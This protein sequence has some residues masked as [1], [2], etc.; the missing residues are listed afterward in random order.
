LQPLPIR[1]TARLGHSGVDR[2]DETR[3]WRSI[4]ELA[5]ARRSGCRPR[6]PWQIHPG[7]GRRIRAPFLRRL[8]CPPARDPNYPPTIAASGMK[9][10][11]R[12]P[13]GP[14]P[15]D[16]KLTP[17]R[18]RRAAG[19]DRTFRPLVYH[20]C[21]RR[22]ARP[23]MSWRAPELAAL[24]VGVLELI[25]VIGPFASATIVGLV[26]IQQK[27][28]GQRASCSDSP[29]R[30]ACRSTTSSNRSCSA[31]RRGFTRSL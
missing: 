31:K 14:D 30:C 11:W 8:A 3:D 10:E 23:H 16:E 1:S 27:A 17:D 7:G 26:A 9:R 25:P 20:C 5:R 6:S 13:E 21:R 19:A 24:T 28:S 18:S 22:L 15:K 4:P 29:S 2:Q 12:C